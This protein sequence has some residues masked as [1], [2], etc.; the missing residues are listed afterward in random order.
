MPAIHVAPAPATPPERGLIASLKPMPNA[1][2][3]VSTTP[4]RMN[5]AKAGFTIVFTRPHLRPTANLVSVFL[6]L[7][8]L[9][10]T[11]LL[12][13]MATWANMSIAAKLS[14]AKN[15]SKDATYKSM[16]VGA[17]KVTVGTHVTSAVKKWVLNW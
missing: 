14:K 2:K 11:N 7:Q 3:W 15:P 13:Q 8:L 9:D 12:F 1:Q 5:A 4:G 10:L 16:M 17:A 6:G